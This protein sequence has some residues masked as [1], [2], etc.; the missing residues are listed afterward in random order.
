MNHRLT[1]TLYVLLLI[2]MP[3]GMAA[4]PSATALQPVLGGGV[5]SVGLDGQEPTPISPTGADPVWSPAGDQIAFVT[6]GGAGL[7]AIAVSDA[8][9]GQARIVADTTDY[10]DQLPSWSA[11]GSRIA[12]VT[13]DGSLYVVPADGSTLTWLLGPAGQGSLLEGYA[14]SSRPAWSPDGARLAI[15][16]LIDGDSEIALVEADGSSMSLLTDMPGDALVPVWS[17]DGS[18]IAFV[19]GFFDGV[20][21]PP[22][23]SGTDDS[24]AVI[25]SPPDIPI[26]DVEMELPIPD[27]EVEEPPTIPEPE[28]EEVP[29]IDEG[30]EPPPPPPSVSEDGFDDSFGSTI[31]LDHGGVY[32]MSADGSDQSRM[33]D[34]LADPW[35]APSWTH[36]GT[37]LVFA[38]VDYSGASVWNFPLHGS[39]PMVLPELDRTYRPSFSPD[40]SRLAAIAI[41]GQGLL[42][43][44]AD[45][46]GATNVL[47]G[48][49]LV[50]SAA[51]SP[52]GQRIAFEVNAGEPGEADQTQGVYVAAADGS[53]AVRIVDSGSQ[54]A[55]S[56]NGSLIAYTAPGP[57]GVA[58]MVVGWD[59]AGAREVVSLPTCPL[60]PAWSPDGSK[61]AFLTY[62]DSYNLILW[63]VNVDGSG[64]TE[65]APGAQT[66]PYQPS[67]SPD[68]T[69][70][71][72]VGPGSGRSD[73][74][75]INADGSGATQLTDLPGETEAPAFSPD[76]SMIAFAEQRYEGERSNGL[77]VVRPDGS[78]LTTLT[79]WTADEDP[80]PTNMGISGGAS[81]SPDGT[82]LA[83]S[84]I[85]G[86][87]LVRSDGSGTEILSLGEYPLIHDVRFSPDGS[88]LALSFD[89]D[90][91][92][93]QQMPGE[94]PSTG[95][96][97][98]IYVVNDD[99]SGL[100][101]VGETPL[102]DLHPLWSPDGTMIVFD[103]EGAGR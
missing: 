23:P 92:D 101:P 51:W 58:L 67:W 37:G 5:W 30:D 8:A 77:F 44:S 43:A 33:S 34:L 15:A 2:V 26:M 50:F 45:G 63:T 13:A 46:T 78:N 48:A 81:W 7:N 22:M 60:M 96:Y 100:R 99:G 70:I 94:A 59:G 25:D 38:V 85:E 28:L 11:D 53:G 75:I 54:P 20:S 64:L 76:G 40:G 84:S 87:A 39:D 95:E 91:E 31:N 79:Q 103:N 65:L 86:V 88:M 12:F 29:T 69:K 49:A 42:V 52:D 55:P 41:E 36:D 66:Y 16:V 82:R 6:S 93:A 21:M 17:P 1:R 24:E 80:G 18:R 4:V 19:N 56:P 27:P 89:L 98:D 68:G 35:T 10:M 72:F 14:R 74:W 47:G 62:D 3:A 97:E 57:S 102:V 83:I 71:A 32:V 90:S 61:I 9:G 73:L